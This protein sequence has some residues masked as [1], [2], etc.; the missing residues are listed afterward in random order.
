MVYDLII[1]GGGPAALSAA[2]YSSRKELKTLVLCKK[3]GG[4]VSEAW[5]VENYLGLGKIK[6]TDFV[7][8]MQEHVRMFKN[9]EI[10][11]DAM[12][13]KIDKEEKE[14]KVST[15]SE[16]FI[17]KTV[18]IASGSKPKRL[19]VKDEGKFTGKGV[20]YC[21]TCD[22][23]MFKDKEVIVVGGG[24]SALDAA[25][26]LSVI[27]KFVY[28]LDISKEFIADK[29]LV[30]KVLINKNVKAIHNAKIVEFIG[31]EK[32]FIKGIIYENLGDNKKN[33]LIVQ[34]VFVEIGSMPALV[35]EAIKLNEKSE[36]VVDNNNMTTE[37]G[38]FAAGDV[39]N[40]KYK[41]IAVSVG[42]GAKAALAIYEYLNS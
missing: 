25:L 1:V 30:E 36:I 26:E 23:P 22:A 32:G 33:N 35:K 8:K 5:E 24:N 34:G 2:I 12:V 40:T 10:K 4:Q 37:P 17:S 19:G 13:N 28:V 38:I 41:Q 27:A 21:A 6:G 14:F 31:D 15:N 42:E 18:L 7:R 20:S 3:I 9:I 39:T 29:F 11:E 16:S